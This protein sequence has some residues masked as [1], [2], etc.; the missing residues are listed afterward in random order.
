MNNQCNR[1]KWSE[2]NQTIFLEFIWNEL[3]SFF[4]SEKLISLTFLI[5]ILHNYFNQLE[6][7]KFKKDFPLFWAGSFSNT[8]TV[9]LNWWKV[10]KKYGGTGFFGVSFSSFLGIY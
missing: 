6:K 8:L 2:N 10:H 4:P 9:T 1:T 7:T 3:I 5:G